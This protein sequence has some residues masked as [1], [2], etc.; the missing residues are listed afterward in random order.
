MFLTTVMMTTPTY[1]VFRAHCE[2]YFGFGSFVC[3]GSAVGHAE[4]DHDDCEN[5]DDEHHHHWHHRHED[6]DHEGDDHLGG[7]D[8]EYDDDG[9]PDF[10]DGN[11]DDDNVFF[12]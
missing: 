8:Y 2:P 11:E 6:D 1:Q 3:L 7:F 9:G 10:D 4:T 12:L 5:G